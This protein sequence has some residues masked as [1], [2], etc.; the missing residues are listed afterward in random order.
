MPS[1]PSTRSRHYEATVLIGLGN[2]LSHQG[3]TEE[4]RARWRQAQA[5]LDETDDP[6][7]EHVRRQLSALAPDTTLIESRMLA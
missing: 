7:A 3:R 4:G 6:R 1:A 2:A 5:V